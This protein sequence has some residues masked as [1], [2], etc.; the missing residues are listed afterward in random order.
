MLG[1]W[2]LLVGVFFVS[3]GFGK[4]FWGVWFLVFF[5]VLGV[6]TFKIGFFF[7]GILSLFFLNVT[8]E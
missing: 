6:F 7:K 5:V 4:D 3:L 2:V 1:F 8:N